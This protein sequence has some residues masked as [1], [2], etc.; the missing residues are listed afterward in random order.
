MIARILLAAAATVAIPAAMLGAAEPVQRKDS[1]AE[2][3][4]CEVDTPVGSRLGGVRRCRTK[5]E[6]EAHKQEARQ[7]VDRIQSFKAVYCEEPR[8]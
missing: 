8:C 7:T 3:R 2:A 4:T 5:A 6:R 1:K